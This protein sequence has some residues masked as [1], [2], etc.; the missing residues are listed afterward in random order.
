MSMLTLMTHKTRVLVDGDLVKV[1]SIAGS[2]IAQ[3]QC[4][5]CH[6]AQYD[7]YVSWLG[8]YDV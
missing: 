5:L 8:P 3:A 6:G 4:D 2:F 1:F 7:V